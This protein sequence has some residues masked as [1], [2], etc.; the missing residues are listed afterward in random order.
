MGD[1]PQEPTE[2]QFEGVMETDGD[3]TPEQVS[4]YLNSQEIFSGA[5]DLEAGDLRLEAFYPFGYRIISTD[6]DEGEFIIGIM[7][8]DIPGF[9][10]DE[11]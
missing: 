5:D 11:D 8:A 3:P 4:E 10:E 2:M 7:L 1:A 6:E 9:N